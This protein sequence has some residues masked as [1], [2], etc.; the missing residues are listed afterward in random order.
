VHLR[1]EGLVRRYGGTLALGG[2]DFEARGGEVTAVIGGNGAGKS[3]LMKILAGAEQPSEGRLSLDGAPVRFGSVRE[4]EQVGVVLIPQELSLLP[5][6]TVAENVFLGR[7]RK[8]PGWRRA[9]VDRASERATAARLLERLGVRIH[10]EARVGALGAGE[11]QMVA[12]A[13]ALAVDARVLI[14]DE[15]T[16]ALG[17]REAEVLARV[18]RELRADGVAVLY[19][20]HRLE[21]LLSLG[22][23]I[24]VLRDGRMVAEAPAAEVDRRWIVGHMAGPSA[25]ADEAAPRTRPVRSAAEAATP[26]RLRVSGLDVDRGPGAPPLSNVTL[27]V[28]PGEI[29]GLYGLVGAGRT[30]LLEALAGARAATGAVTLDGQDLGRRDLRGRIAAGLLLVPEDRRAAG[31]VPEASV[32]DNLTLSAIERLRRGPWQPFLHGGRIRQAVDDMIRKLDVRPRAPGRAVQ[33]LSGG[34]QQKV[35]F[36]RAFLAGPR[37]L[38]LD[39]PTRGVDVAARDQLHA[40]IA[41]LAADGCAVLVSS[42][43]AEE[44]CALADRVLILSAGRLVAELPRDNLTPAALVAAA[45]L[46]ETP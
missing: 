24:V 42:S 33:L 14:L 8:G 34:N 37:A 26:P 9:L 39:E 1:A 28:R 12:I 18:V 46:G 22:D 10:P 36:G 4:A 44:L 43:D 7:E 17:G 21:E 20:S 45:A 29:V 25:P 5:E 40:V 15:P 3:T 27:D 2:V 41:D 31:I 19:I 32:A 30:E 38:L 35:L 11:Q 16:A 6:L 13:R 23:R